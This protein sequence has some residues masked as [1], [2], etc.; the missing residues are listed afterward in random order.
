[1]ILFLYRAFFIN[2]LFLLA[3]LIFV[4]TLSAQTFKGGLVAGFNLSQL[5]GDKLAGYNKIGLNAG[6]RVSVDLSERWGFS[7]QLLFSQ[8]G[9]SRTRDDDPNSIYDKIRLNFVEAPFLFHFTDW[10]FELDA[11]FSYARLM[12]H[13][14]IDFTGVDISDNQNYR[15]NIYSAIVGVTFWPNETIGWNFRWL[16]TFSDLQ[17]NP[18]DN[19]FIGRTISLRLYYML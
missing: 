12:N 11:G 17:A 5:D 13:R 9:S 1:M 10:K 18:G 8:T 19:R 14:V 6:G 15:P 7:M 16:R 4:P 2:A 3:L